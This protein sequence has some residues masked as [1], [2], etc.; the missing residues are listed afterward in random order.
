MRMNMA[1]VIPEKI[2]LTKLEEEYDAV[3]Q[4]IAKLQQENMNMTKK[5]KELETNE[6]DNIEEINSKENTIIGLTDNDEK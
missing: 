4:E 2:E 5:L 3:M 6:S 1:E